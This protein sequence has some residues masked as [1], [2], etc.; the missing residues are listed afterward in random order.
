VE[1][2]QWSG[3]VS[4]G[5][6]PFLLQEQSDFA[7]LETDFMEEDNTGTTGSG[8][9]ARKRVRFQLASMKSLDRSPPTKPREQ[10]HIASHERV[11]PTIPRLPI[12]QAVPGQSQLCGICR[13]I[14][15]ARYVDKKLTNIQYLGSW[16]D[17]TNSQTCQFCRLVVEAFTRRKDQPLPQPND[18]IRL[19]NA[20]S[21][22]LGVE[23]SPFD[24]L[25]SEA[26]SN[27]YDLRSIARDTSK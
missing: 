16:D 14:D 18:R 6:I 26:F 2:L 24:R 4:P 13:D 8:S 10:E 11:P 21:W 23:L 3:F 20:L 5:F 1:A 19:T 27:K 22:E 17:I 9:R 25:K 7:K 12:P 15:F